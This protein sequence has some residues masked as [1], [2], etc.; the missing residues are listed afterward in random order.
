MLSLLTRLPGLLASTALFAL[1]LLT[2]ADVM[3]RSMLNAPIEVAADLTRVL[4]AIMV[5]SVLPVL[6]G[7]GQHVSVDLLDG[8]F[9][10]WGLARWRDAV[11]NVFC[12]LLL[13]WPAQR[14]WVLA[15]RSRSYGDVS[16]Y[17][18]LPLF[19]IGWF[20]AAMTAVTALVLLIRG[21]VFAF[22]PHHLEERQ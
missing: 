21:L 9:R 1:M 16:E 11:G 2:F 4:M 10:R 20:I 17:L 3:L 6:S 18:R 12:G 14:V 15:E 22:A 13:V 5:F 8:P 7:K 19:Y